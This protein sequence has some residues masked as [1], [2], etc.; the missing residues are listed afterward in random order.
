MMGWNISVYRQKDGGAE[1]APEKCD[2]GGRLAIWQAAPD[3]L[4]WIEDLVK[5]GKAILLA[6]NAGYP[7]IYTA[8]AGDLIPTILAGPPYEN[9]VW[10]REDFDT[11]IEGLY[12]GRTTIDQ[13]VIDSCKPDE[14]LY[15]KSWDES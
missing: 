6:T 7:R 2:T 13:S 9:K 14:W 8:L 3:G 12:L 4:R 15:I 11:V 5:A 10:L 1:P